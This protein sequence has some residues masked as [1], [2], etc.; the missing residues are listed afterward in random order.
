M[1]RPFRRCEAGKVGTP[2]PCSLRCA[3]ERIHPCQRGQPLLGY[4]FSEFQTALTI[5]KGSLETVLGHWTS[6]DE[7]RRRELVMRALR[8]CD[9][10]VGARAVARRRRSHL[11]GRPSVYPSASEAGSASR[12]CRGGRGSEAA[13]AIPGPRPGWGWL[14]ASSWRRSEDVLGQGGDDRPQAS[15]AH[16]VNDCREPGPRAHPVSKSNA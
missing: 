8:G 1:S 2:G 16:R 4:M 14:G 12:R 15:A 10:L 3:G 7:D 9:D 13:P 6:L 5:A 11:A